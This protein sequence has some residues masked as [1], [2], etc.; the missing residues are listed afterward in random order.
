[1][2]KSCGFGCPDDRFVIGVQGQ[3]SHYRL[4]VWFC[5]LPVF[6]FLKGCRTDTKSTNDLL[7]LTLPVAHAGTHIDG[8]VV[9]HTSHT[10]PWM[11]FKSSCKRHADALATPQRALNCPIM[12]RVDAMIPPCAHVVL[13]SATAPTPPRR[14]RM[15]LYVC[16]SAF[17]FACV[18]PAEVLCAVCACARGFDVY[19]FIECMH[20]QHSPGLSRSH[21]K[22]QF[23]IGRNLVLSRICRTMRNVVTMCASNG[24]ARNDDVYWFK[25][26]ARARLRVS[27]VRSQH[28][29]V[30]VCCVYYACKQNTYNEAR[31]CVQHK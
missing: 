25:W 29:C 9:H 12:M 4:C 28:E 30:C 26:M 13:C 16:S 31:L 2:C 11:H 8:R 7:G 1:M 6:I 24:R 10:S 21:Q 17:P 27:R 23:P 3:H 20:T 19:K 14:Q 18:V 5:L 22:A 15:C